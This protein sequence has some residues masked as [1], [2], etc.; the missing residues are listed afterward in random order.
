[1]NLDS[2][3]PEQIKQLQT[4]LTPKM[5]K[6]IPITPT[7]KQ[8]AA[9]L[10]NS[11]REL[12]YGGAAGG[13]KSVY[14]LAAALQYVDTP[15]Y[16]AVL[17]RR[18]FSDLML[19][20]AL[21]PMSQEWLTPFLAS[22]EVRW[23]DKEK[24]Y[25][26]PSGATVSFGYLQDKGDELRYQ[27]AEFQFVG[28]DEVTHI[29]PEAYRYLFSRLRRLK[30]SN[31]PIRMRASANPGGPFGDYYYQRFFVDNKDSKKRIFLPAGLKDNPHLD[32]DEYRESLAELDPITRAQL[33]NGDWE[34]RPKGDL[35]DRSWLL[36][37]NYQDIPEGT[38]WVRFWDLASIDP[39]Y[40]KK[41]TNTKEPDWTIGFKLGVYNGYYYIGDII[42]VQKQPGDI[43]KLIRETAEADGYSCAIR[44]EEEGGSSGAAN[45]DRYSRIILAGL[46][47][48]GVKPV[49][50]KIERARPVASACQV[51]KVFISNR[52]R[53]LVDFY[54]QM[55][56]F[57]NGAHDD[58]V[59]GFSGAFAYFKPRIG[60]LAPPP[61][62][63]KADNIRYVE[64]DDY[65]DESNPRP[66]YG[67]GGSYWHRGMSAFKGR[68]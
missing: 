40:R 10:M 67:C 50:S 32:V 11:I 19:P 2:L 26:F 12:L 8:T 1:M 37:I 65:E 63:A 60:N 29:A 24:R 9:L 3:S 14:M 68:R 22:G 59:D 4:T 49:V 56:A 27:G 45:I 17:F 44:M 48:A 28:M 47:F 66:M 20:G 41:N 31:I 5:T 64:E 15:G 6:F 25:T 7:A 21:I 62:Y 54:A 58:M 51:G 57:P 23:Q 53:N 18:T 34:I 55:D 16:A 61:A 39:K 36:T 38:R 13:G 46:D 43:E 30:G 35:F 33:E 42:K 52:C